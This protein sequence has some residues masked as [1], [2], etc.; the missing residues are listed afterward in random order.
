LQAL[1]RAAL[2]EGI[3]EDHRHALLLQTL[4]PDLP[5]SL[6]GD[7]V[8]PD[9]LLK[10]PL[11]AYEILSAA[12]SAICAIRDGALAGKGGGSHPTHARSRAKLE[13]VLDEER[14][15]IAC[16]ASSRPRLEAH[17]ETQTPTVAG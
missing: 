4:N 1:R 10:N 9:W 12:S 16:L 11:E 13:I 6:R 17:W 2:V 3:P 15:R 8:T 14:F 7:I 5:F